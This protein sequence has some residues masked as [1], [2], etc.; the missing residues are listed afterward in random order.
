[1]N[2]LQSMKNKLS[3]LGL[4]DMSSGTLVSAELECYASELQRVSDELDGLLR[5]RFVSTAEDRGLT[6]YEDMTGFMRLDNTTA[7]RRASILGAMA[8]KNTDNRL[9]DM[10]MLKPVF[11][12]SGSFSE[13][14]G[15]I[16]FDCSDTLT[17]Q[18]SAALEAQ[19]GA[20]APL[21]V[22][23]ALV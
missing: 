2:I 6:V 9:S 4:Y 22:T 10:D 16:S 18:Q 21:G 8:I 12:V 15:A 3:P 7:G 17:P 13:S 5:E 14:A 23:F 1:M 19:M 20:F 11:G